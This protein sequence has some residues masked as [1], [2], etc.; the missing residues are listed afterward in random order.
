MTST[1]PISKTNRSTAHEVL[2]YEVMFL[3][4]WQ[5]FNTSGCIKFP[6]KPWND[7]VMS[8][9]KNY[10]SVMNIMKVDKLLVP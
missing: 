7:F 10:R 6:D 4:S 3:S 1:N 2:F 8:V 9:K 5:S